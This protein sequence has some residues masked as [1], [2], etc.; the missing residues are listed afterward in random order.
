VTIVVATVAVGRVYRPLRRFATLAVSQPVAFRRFATLCDTA[1][2]N[3]LDS[4][5]QL[6][7]TESRIAELRDEPACMTPL[8]HGVRNSPR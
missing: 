7:R 1:G 6:T 4:I 5:S 3:N 8:L 2:G